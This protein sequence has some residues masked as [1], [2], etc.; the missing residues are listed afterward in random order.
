MARR[1]TPMGVQ[2]HPQLK[3][4]ID[5]YLDGQNSRQIAAWCKPCLSHTAI[6]NYAKNVIEP[7]MKQAELLKS[8]L[9]PKKMEILGV[10]GEEQTGELGLQ[11][12]KLALLGRPVLAA[13]E[14]RL[15]ALQ[16]RHDRLNLIVEER[17][18]DMAEAPGGK[19]GLLTRDYKGKN[20][21]QVV[22][23]LDTGLLS[24]FREHERQV[25]IELGQWQ[26]AAAPN[27]AIQIVMPSAP[28]S[29]PHMPT[30]DIALPKR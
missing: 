17:A 22:Y 21:D 28:A 15:A 16:D 25:A 20:A 19:S 18:A 1:K 6:Y 4:I 3:Q 7:T 11:T 27:V 26:E 2:V 5:A 14:N 30:I 29:G 8:V 12:A 9:P 23:K 10:P 13:R 24:E